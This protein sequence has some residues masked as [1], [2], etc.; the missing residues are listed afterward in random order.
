M[1]R[2]YIISILTLIF[3][4]SLFCGC[5]TQE[6]ISG[7]YYNCCTAEDGKSWEYYDSMYFELNDD[8]TG[9]LMDH[10]KIYPVTWEKNDNKLNMTYTDTVWGKTTDTI[11]KYYDNYYGSNDATLIVYLAGSEYAFSI[12]EE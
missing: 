8:S 1:F 11:G 2:H 9:I 12:K 6:D 7:R 3:V 10:D 4:S 5:G